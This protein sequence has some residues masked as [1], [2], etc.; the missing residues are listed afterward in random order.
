MC[1]C[2]SGT[3]SRGRHFIFYLVQVSCARTLKKYFYLLLK[4]ANRRFLPFT[5]KS[6]VFSAW[7]KPVFQKLLCQQRGGQVDLGD[8]HPLNKKHSPPCPGAG[9]MAFV[10][11]L[12]VSCEPLNIDAKHSSRA[13]CSVEH[14]REL[15]RVAVGHRRRVCVRSSV[16]TQDVTRCM[17][18]VC[19]YICKH[20]RVCALH[21][22][23]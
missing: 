10:V 20:K 17:A 11:L 3:L 22:S 15:R 19:H 8:K 4:W 18:G 1:A 12:C 14:L 9:V 21:S 2:V 13:A 6:G 23:M 7:E 5:P 16:L